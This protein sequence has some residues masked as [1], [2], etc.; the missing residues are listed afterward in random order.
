MQSAL[1]IWEVILFFSKISAFCTF[2]KPSS[3]RKAHFNAHGVDI[4]SPGETRWYYKSRA[5]TAIFEGFDKI[6]VALTEI[7]NNP[8]DWSDE[9]VAKSFLFC[10]LLE[11]YS[12]ILQKSILYDILQKR[13]V[14]FSYAVGKIDDF[15]KYL[16]DDLLTDAEFEKCHTDALARPDGT[17]QRRC[18]QV[19]NYKSLYFKVIDNIVGMIEKHFHDVD[20]FSFLDL[21]NP[22]IFPQ[23]A[24]GVPTDKIQLLTEKYGTLFNIPNLQSQLAFVY[25]DKDSQK[26]NSM[27]L[28]KYIFK[29]N[30]QSCF[31]EMVKLLK[32]NAV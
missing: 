22:K 7:T 12:K 19:I 24:D 10:F 32:L 25:K 20:S 18:E 3:D 23:W 21:I 13:Y 1:N 17:P 14:H 30:V 16:C 26:D 8:Q 2:S 29:V 6:K 31:P 28:L 15:R 27:E 11:L 4:P 9:T 5:V